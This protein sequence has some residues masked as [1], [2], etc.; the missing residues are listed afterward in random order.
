LDEGFTI[1][2]TGLPV[3]GKSDLSKALHKE[4]LK[5][6]L[7]AE[8][9]DDTILRKEYCQK[10]DDSTS[11]F[12]LSAEIFGYFSEILN[13]NQI[14]SIVGAVS[15]SRSVREKIKDKIEN[16]IEIHLDTEADSTLQVEKSSEVDLEIQIDT[17]TI[18]AACEEIISLLEELT[19]IQPVSE[20]YTDEEK[21]EIDA[22]LKSLGYM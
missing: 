1:W 19:F 2:I 5:R 8:L 22:R 14:V 10:M 6:G 11:D 13:R 17:K 18:E 15:P 20:D 21:E 4:I 16:F 7:R 12:D 3:K 9:L